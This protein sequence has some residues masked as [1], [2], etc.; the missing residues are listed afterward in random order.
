MKNRFSKSCGSFCVAPP[1]DYERPACEGVSVRLCR[2]KFTVGVAR[3]FF[4]TRD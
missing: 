4:G 3:F 2:V 1:G